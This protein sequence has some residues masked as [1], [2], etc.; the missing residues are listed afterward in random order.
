MMK[1]I[2]KFNTLLLP[3]TIMFALNLVVGASYAFSLVLY[4]LVITPLIAFNLFEIHNQCFDHKVFICIFENLW[5]ILSFFW[6]LN[7]WVTGKYQQ[8]Y[9]M[10]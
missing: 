8:P 5:L 10:Y 7:V 3:L 1:M 6:M 4:F 9:Y 2:D